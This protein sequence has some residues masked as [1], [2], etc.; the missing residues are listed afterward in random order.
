MMTHKQGAVAIDEQIS[1]RVELEQYI[2]EQA[3]RL[4]LGEGTSFGFRLLEDT[5]E[6]LVTYSKWLNSQKQILSKADFR[7]LVKSQGWKGEEKDYLKIAAA[8]EN[9]SPQDLA[10]I[11]PA[12]IFRLARNRK[13]YQEVIDQLATL[14]EI[15]QSVVR[16]LIQA[17]RKPRQ[18]KKVED[19]NCWRLSEDGFVYLQIPPIYEED[20]K[21]GTILHRLMKELGKT[22]Q[23]VIVRAVEVLELFWDGHLA[24]VSSTT[25]I[26]SEADIL[27]ITPQLDINKFTYL[28]VNSQQISDDLKPESNDDLTFDYPTVASVIENSTTELEDNQQTFVLFKSTESNLDDLQA[29]AF[30]F[31]RNITQPEDNQKISAV[32]SEVREK[33]L[34]GGDGNINNQTST[35]EQEPV[36]ML[37]QI[38]QKAATWK[39]ISDATQNYGY[40]QQQAWDALTPFERRRIMQMMPEDIRKLA[41][42]RDAGKIIDFYEI[43]AGL[44]R[45]KQTADLGWEIVSQSRLEHFLIE[46]LNN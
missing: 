1:A 10:K 27:T 11:E 45:V 32:S 5:T 7:E 2:E 42:T 41:E 33:N 46:V 40:Y 35:I 20:K 26:E 8:F 12:T 23:G 25:V 44:Y 14:P 21:T 6:R 13:K 9:F 15:N 4:T 22:A 37:I 38:F 31:Q 16:G 29:G 39:E 34:T 17:Q 28:D 43:R 18:P 24:F 30:D 3:V 36:D 19:P